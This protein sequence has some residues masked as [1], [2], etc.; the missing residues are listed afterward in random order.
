[1][2]PREFKIKIIKNWVQI[3]SQCSQWLAR[4]HVTIQRC[5]AAPALKL[6]NRKTTSLLSPE[7]KEIFLPRLAKNNNNLVVILI[8]ISSAQNQVC[9][10]SSLGC[11]PRRRQLGR[12]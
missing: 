9:C 2:F 4:C 1:M 11:V 5:S 12:S 3:V 7:V 8:I 6:W 10:I